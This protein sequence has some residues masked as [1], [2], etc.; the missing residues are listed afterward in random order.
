MEN[1]ISISDTS[2]KVYDVSEKNTID[3]SGQNINFTY[4][5]YLSGCF[6]DIIGER[7]FQPDK[8]YKVV[9]ND[10]LHKK[11][12]GK[13]TNVIH[14]SDGK[15]VKHAELQ[16]VN[17]QYNL[18]EVVK[19]AALQSMFFA[20]LI[21]N[22]EILAHLKEI[23][24]GQHDDRISKIE[25]VVTECERRNFNLTSDQLT[26]KETLLLEGLTQLQ[27]EVKRQIDQFKEPWLNVAVIKYNRKIEEFI[28]P[29]TE[30][31]LWLF[32]GYECLSRLYSSE[33][34]DNGN[35]GSR[36]LKDF[37]LFLHSFDFDKIGDLSRNVRYNREF[38]L[39][40][41]WSSL[42]QLTQFP[43]NMCGIGIT[44]TGKQ[45]GDLLE[46]VSQCHSDGIIMTGNQLKD[47]QMKCKIC[48]RPLIKS[49]K[50]YCPYCCNEKK[51]KRNDILAISFV[52]GVGVIY[53]CRKQI[54]NFVKK[55]IKKDK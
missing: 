34:K 53:H 35:L 1:E 50:K 45:L 48:G 37:S 43:D 23:K 38:P 28:L 40:S 30:S 47:L 5:K 27:H 22:N 14:G 3:I 7:A 31:F 41:F 21:Q 51:K 8:L 54:I 12:N 13:W 2:N 44:M 6:L 55:L 46:D 24:Q 18:S 49:E 32:K 15:I 25:S 20:I 19:L 52:G 11:P 36:T 42:K 17:M 10:I 26:T 9:G 4:N 39:E 16:E 33:Q 29:L